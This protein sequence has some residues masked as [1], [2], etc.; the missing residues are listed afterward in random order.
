MTKGRILV[1]DADAA[2]R[3]NLQNMLQ[4]D[5]YEAP[6][7]ASCRAAIQSF[8]ASRPDAL[9]VAGRL[10]DGTAL[11]VLAHVKR[12]DAEVACVVLAKYEEL[13]VAVQ[14]LQEG[15]EQFLTKP[16]QVPAFLLVVDRVL[17]NQRNR[18]RR[19]QD[20]ARAA[21]AEIDPFLGSSPVIRLL[22][23]RARRVAGANVPILI[24]GETGTGKG[25]LAAWIHRHGSRSEECFLDLNC[26]G[27]S[28]EFLESELFGHEKGSFTGAV[29][30]KLGLLEVAHRG[31]LFLDEIGD[32]PLSVQPKLLKVLE[33]KKFRR[34]GDVRERQVDIRLIAASH[35]QLDALVEKKEFRAD[36]YFRINT[37]V[38]KIPA[39]R[40]RPDDLTPLAELLLGQIALEL[41]REPMRLTPAAL[42]KLHA[43]RWP[44]NVRELRNALERAALLTHGPEIGPEDFSFEPTPS[45]AAAPAAG[46]GSLLETEKDLIRKTLEKERGRVGRAADSLGISRSS[47]Y[48]KIR[49]YGIVVSRN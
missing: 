17:E 18:R 38:L 7:A 32:L 9:V 43:H 26:A 27:L 23:D 48:E 30:T 22:H 1:V 35:A 36:L 47:L 11:D 29:A 19:L 15:A 40:D 12:A 5:G 31:T 42:E 33:E 24:H 34:L 46:D 28:P 41:D 39:L 16:V 49:K 45:I 37:V 25:V 14:A 13:D 6:E 8:E 44:G 2:I 3:E 10:P 21:R 4:I 20:E